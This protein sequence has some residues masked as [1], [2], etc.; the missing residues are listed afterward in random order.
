MKGIGYGT[1]SACQFQYLMG[2]FVKSFF[3]S[4]LTLYTSVS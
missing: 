4:L 3:E 1:E 2:N